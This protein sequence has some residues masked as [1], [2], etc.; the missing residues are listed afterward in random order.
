MM[1][2]KLSLAKPAYRHIKKKKQKPKP[3]IISEVLIEKYKCDYC[4]KSKS[5]RIWKGVGKIQKSK[6]PEEASLEH[7]TD[8]TEQ[9]RH[10]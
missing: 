4:E 5:S 8:D 6:E 9:S 7:K 10:F 3:K 1:K 2:N